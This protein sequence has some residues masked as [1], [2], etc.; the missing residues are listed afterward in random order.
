MK[1]LALFVFF[2]ICYESQS[3]ATRFCGQKLERILNA[4]CVDG[5]NGRQISKK[6]INEP[7][8]PQI[9]DLYGLT[10]I[11]NEPDAL[12]N[13]LLNDVLHSEG[14]NGFAKTRRQRHLSGVYDECCRKGCTFNEL[15]GY[16]I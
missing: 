8:Y 14:L 15:A 3:A 11:D 16:C 1:F 5:F 7:I 10:D 13:S 9:S 6:S 4:V 12:S 2:A